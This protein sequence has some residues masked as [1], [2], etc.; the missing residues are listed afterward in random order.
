MNVT[1]AGLLRAAVLIATAA[2]TVL[3][4]GCESASAPDYKRL[5]ITGIPQPYDVRDV[6]PFSPAPSIYFVNG[7][8]DATI[9]LNS[10]QQF[11]VAFGDV[12]TSIAATAPFVF[13][14]EAVANGIYA[15]VPGPLQPRAFLPSE[16]PAAYRVATTM[17]LLQVVSMNMQSDDKSA[18]FLVGLPYVERYPQLFAAERLF[19][20][21]RAGASSYGAVTSLTRYSG[22]PVKANGFPA[23]SSL[24][25]FHVI[26]TP[27]GAFF[28]KKPAVMELQPDRSGKL[29]LA[30]PP[31]PFDYRLVN[32]PIPL[33]AVD[34]PDGDPVGELLG[35]AHVSHAGPA[36]SGE[37]DRNTWPFRRN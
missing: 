17:H 20:G 27:F 22:D 18:R 26:E 14:P 31:I 15:P 12:N 6:S 33:Y 30:L 8:V 4:A 10:G 13:T 2:A 24:A 19:E 21:G 16:L 25:L 7:R 34:R 28:N 37:P 35:A 1:G 5:P 32:G 3:F 9:R 23:R 11:T 36:S 29:A